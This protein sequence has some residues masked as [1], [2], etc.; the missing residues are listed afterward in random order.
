MASL[1]G[2][3]LASFNHDDVPPDYG[4]GRGRGRHSDPGLRQRGR[5]AWGQSRGRRSDHGRG[6][7][8][9]RSSDPTDAIINGIVAQIRNSVPGTP[10]SELVRPFLSQLD[11][12][13]TAMLVKHMSSAG[14]SDEAWQLFDW[15]R[16]T[17]EEGDD[18]GPSSTTCD[19]FLYT[20]MIALCC[21]TGG[22]SGRR[23]DRRELQTALDLS[24][25]MTQ[26]G[27]ARNVH[28]F[29]ALM[30]VCIKA[31]QYQRALEVY[32][33][34]MQAERCMPNVVTYN[35]LIDLYGKTGQCGEAARVL[36]KMRAEVRASSMG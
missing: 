21:N 1:G 4:Q 33:I 9:S 22:A 16:A 30:N 24:E 10:V 20:A 36:D 35:T 6:G 15:L 3:Q 8:R 18:A 7:A 2:R 34:D 17:G 11:S 28:T 23:D 14:Y 27:I 19:V 25:E 32:T 13:G 12:R 31:G 26:K 5:V 29:S